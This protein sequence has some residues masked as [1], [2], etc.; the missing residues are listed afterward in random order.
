MKEFVQYKRQ[1]DNIFFGASTEG[2][3]VKK[4]HRYLDFLSVEP[5]ISPFKNGLVDDWARGSER[6]KCYIIGGLTGS[7]NVYSW[8]EYRSVVN[9][10]TAAFEAGKKVFIKDN[11]KE[12]IPY[13]VGLGMNISK[14]ISN[15]RQLPWEL[16][17]KSKTAGVD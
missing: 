12:Y 2:Y 14:H 13:P 17:T 5:F 3:W 15:F 1:S 7:G 10:V 8:T 6:I 11:I 9:L 4:P 16:Y